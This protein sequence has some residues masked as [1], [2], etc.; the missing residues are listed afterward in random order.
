[1]K[2]KATK[3]YIRSTTRKKTLYSISKKI[4][5]IEPQGFFN[6]SYFRSTMEIRSSYDNRIKP[7]KSFIYILEMSHIESSR[8]MKM[9]NIAHG[10]LFRESERVQPF[11]RDKS[12][13]GI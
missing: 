3:M 8:S 13:I 9:N 2:M 5:T 11:S 7:L 1:M 10:C 6:V 4:F 12:Y